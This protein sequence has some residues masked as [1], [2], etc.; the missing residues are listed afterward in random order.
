MLIGCVFCGRP[1]VLFENASPAYLATLER[2]SIFGGLKRAA[3]R[4]ALD[5]ASHAMAAWV[6]LQATE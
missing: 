5:A 1:Q 6:Q 4:G 3:T 2:K